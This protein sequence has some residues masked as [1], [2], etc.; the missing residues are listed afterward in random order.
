M[1]AF[2][3]LQCAQQRQVCTATTP[4]V[5]VPVEMRALFQTDRWRIRAHVLVELRTATRSQ[6]FT[7]S[8]R[9]TFAEKHALSA[10]TE[11]MPPMASVPNVQLVSTLTMPAT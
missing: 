1:G 5:P 6:V 2:A 9:A 3:M 11:A 4:P 7:V 10:S 8:L